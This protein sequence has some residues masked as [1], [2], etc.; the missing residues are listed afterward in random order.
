MTYW[1]GDDVV[2]PL[3]DREMQR[4]GMLIEVLML[5]ELVNFS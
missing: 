5:L 1:K 4:L 2:M 3:Q